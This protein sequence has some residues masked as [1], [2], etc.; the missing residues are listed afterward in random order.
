MIFYFCINKMS[1]NKYN[2]SFAQMKNDIEEKGY[3][4]VFKEIK[5]IEM[6]YRDL[7]IKAFGTSSDSSIKPEYKDKEFRLVYNDKD[8]VHNVGKLI[9]A[10]FSNM[11][12]VTIF[13]FTFENSDGKTYVNTE[14]EQPTIL[15]IDDKE[16]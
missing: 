9:G 3:Q 11:S 6:Q 10:T 15:M 4:Q 1:T 2:S 16:T 12:M 14:Y 5:S 13:T 7:Y 8:L